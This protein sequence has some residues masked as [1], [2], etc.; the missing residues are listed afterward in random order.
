MIGL[1]NR[2]DCMIE[3]RP[4]PNMW[5]SLPSLMRPLI[6]R[7][8]LTVADWKDL[9]FRLASIFEAFDYERSDE[10]VPVE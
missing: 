2:L 3:S 4:D 6:G 1:L 5:S 9:G 8:N 7:Y 10:T